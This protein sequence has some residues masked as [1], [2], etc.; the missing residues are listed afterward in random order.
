MT[1]TRHV[2]LVR[3]AEVNNPDRVI[4][5]LLPGFA[6]SARGRAQAAAAAE[7][8]A[9][10]ARGPLAIVASPLDRAQETARIIAGRVGVAE[11]VTD[12][13]LT[14]AASGLDGLPRRLGVRHI[15]RR[16]LDAEARARIEAPRKV[17]LR[18]AQAVR[19]ALGS[20]TAELVIVSHQFPIRVARVAFERRLGTPQADRVAALAPW[21]YA[22]ARCELASITTIAFEGESFAGVSYWEPDC[23]PAGAAS[24]ARR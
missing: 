18:M 6:L 23:P 5:G 15:V 9:A 4:Y 21:L 10:V 8:V 2:H 20:T 24:P 13:L 7:R 16:I 12:P 14:E 17:A 19:A 11:I 1:R 22:R 3:H